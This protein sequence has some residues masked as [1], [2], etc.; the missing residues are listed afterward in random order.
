[1]RFKKIDLRSVVP[2]H[3]GAVVSVVNIAHVS[4]AFVGTL[5]HNS[6]IGFGIIM[7]FQYNFEVG[8]G[9]KIFSGKTVRGERAV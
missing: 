7:V 5:K 3:T 4:V 9:R 2:R 1:M 8:V 6:A